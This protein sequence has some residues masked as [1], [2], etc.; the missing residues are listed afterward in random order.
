MSCFQVRSTKPEMETLSF[1]HFQIKLDDET[2]TFYHNEP[3]S[4]SGSE[5]LYQIIFFY[6][7]NSAKL[8]HMK[9]KKRTWV[10]ALEHDDH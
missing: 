6:L 7:F 3:S 4:V 5:L 9:I 1:F 10:I 8:R 2:V